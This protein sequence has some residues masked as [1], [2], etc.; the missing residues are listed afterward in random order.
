MTLA[1]APG[2]SADGRSNRSVVVCMAN[3]DFGFGIFWS[4]ADLLEPKQAVVVGWLMFG[5][6]NKCPPLRNFFVAWGIYTN[7][8]RT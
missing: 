2:Q 4:V 1:P 7:F 5:P 3:D 6:T 8:A